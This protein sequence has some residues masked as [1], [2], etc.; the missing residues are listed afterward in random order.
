MSLGGGMQLLLHG[1]LAVQWGHSLWML[2]GLAATRIMPKIFGSVPAGMLCD[3]VPRTRILPVTR[4]L[5]AVASLL[6][7]VGFA[8]P[9]P[10]FWVLAASSLG[11]AA[12]VLDLPAGRS[13]LGDICPSQDLYTLV[14]VERAGGHTAALIGPLLAFELTSWP[15]QPAALIASAAVLAVAALQSR[16]LPEARPRQTHDSTGIGPLVAYLKDTPTA[17]LLM[18]VGVAPVLVDRG[19]ALALP[20]RGGGASTGLALAAPEVGA[21]LAAAML[22]SARYRPGW[23]AILGSAVFYALFVGIAS[24]NLDEG[25]VLI[26]ALAAAGVAKIVMI[27][28]AHARLQG[29]VPPAVR[30]RVFAL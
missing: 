8:A 2:A 11:G 20:S 23:T 3:R 7:L 25:E 24:Q 28:T 10:L 29:I 30:G 18:L 19:I 16:K 21:L 6:P 13:A 26:A 12:H 14:A 9:W 22:A 27:V 5:T 15:G 4:G 1:W 17:V